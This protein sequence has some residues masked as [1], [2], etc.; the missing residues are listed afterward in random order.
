M[1]AVASARLSTP[2]GRISSIRLV[3]SAPGAAVFGGV[4]VRICADTREAPMATRSASTAI[5]EQAS[6]A[7][8][9]SFLT[10]TAHLPARKTGDSAEGEKVAHSPAGFNLCSRPA[11]RI[12]D[13]TTTVVMHRSRAR[14]YDRARRERVSLCG[15]FHSLIVP[16]SRV[17]NGCA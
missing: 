17:M 5:P 6:I 4:Y 11:P 3:Q 12:G 10:L 1:R 8:T 13:G 7:I 2:G 14:H 15:T 9:A 16:C